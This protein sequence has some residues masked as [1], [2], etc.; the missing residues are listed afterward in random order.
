M[1][2]CARNQKILKIFKQIVEKFDLETL[3][4]QQNNKATC[5]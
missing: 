1:F 5:C 3:N 2:K 4:M